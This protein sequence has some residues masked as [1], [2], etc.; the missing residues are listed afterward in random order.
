MTAALKSIVEAAQDG[1]E[2]RR[3][4]KPVASTSAWPP[5][6]DLEAL[7]EKEPHPPRSIMEGLPIGY[8]TGSFGHGG[9]GKSQIELFRA[10]C[11]A[12][13]RPC[14]G[15]NVER[16]RVM[17]LSCEDRADVLHWR[18]TRICRYLGITLANLHGWL[19]AIDL[20][21]RD[22]LLFATDPRT[23]NSLT[24]AYGILAERI[25]QSGIEVLF[26]DGISDTYGDSEIARGP[27][28]RFIN[29]LLALIP[30]DSGAVV[31]IGHVNRA[32][33]GNGATTEGYSGST[34]WH[35]S[36]RARWYL[37]PEIEQ[38]EDNARARRTGKLIL[39]LQKSNHGEIGTSIEFAWD[40]D[41]HL[42][43]GQVTAASLFDVRHQ[44]REEQR[45]ILLALQA[46]TRAAIVVPAA[47]TGRRTAYHVLT[48]Q[49]ACPDSLRSGK[50]AVR[51]FW[52]EIEA[53][54]AMGHVRDDSIRRADRHYTA[55]LALTPEGL[56]ACG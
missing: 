24:A 3:A 12:A 45:G 17:F 53:L 13:G 1:A 10:V 4:A 9:A 20:V 48:A 42:F 7:S 44:Q 21:G 27:V 23:G 35:N 55:T 14:W 41:A 30:P 47:T 46:C 38:G 51:R 32:T 49:A 54:R 29:S 40:D 43:I 5:A 11:I 37:Y 22:S 8:P 50:P 26:A 28:K 36:C 6:L 19:E 18:L 56:R 25:H 16:R 15:L 33:A 52:R 31:L 2:S 34:A 39:E